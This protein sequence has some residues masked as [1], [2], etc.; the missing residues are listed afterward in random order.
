MVHPTRADSL[1]QRLAQRLEP[2]QA[3]A[4]VS[5]VIGLAVADRL[6]A[7]GLL[8]RNWMLTNTGLAV[9]D[10]LLKKQTDGPAD[11]MTP[12]LAAE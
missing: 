4:V 11:V 8:N 7:A 10:I 6:R 3:D 2:S 9:R 12:K 5:E 1:A